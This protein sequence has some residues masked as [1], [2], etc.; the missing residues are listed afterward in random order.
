MILSTSVPGCDVDASGK[1]ALV[2]WFDVIMGIMS[3]IS[4]SFAHQLNVM[5]LVCGIIYGLMMVSG[6]ICGLLALKKR[7]TFLLGVY[8]HSLLPLLIALVLS[9]FIS[10]HRH[11]KSEKTAVSKD[12]QESALL[13]FVILLL[14]I[15]FRTWF[16]KF[17]YYYLTAMKLGLEGLPEPCDPSPDSIG[18]PSLVKSVTT[19]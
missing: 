9:P 3:I 16:F 17:A 4:V 10:M 8:V 7:N 18:K 12:Q 1:I 19:S 2:A 13:E 14:Y 5:K 6:A 15:L 11:Q